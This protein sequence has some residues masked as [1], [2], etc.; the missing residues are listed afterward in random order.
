MMLLLP[1]HFVLFVVVPEAPEILRI[2][3][4]IDNME[5]YWQAAV[6]NPDGPV[7]DY[8]VRVKEKDESGN[9]KICTQHQTRSSSMMC[10]VNDLRSGK[11]YI[12]Q[13]AARNVA[14]YSAF[15]EAEA[16]TSKPAGIIFAFLMIEEH[17]HAN[18][19]FRIPA[20]LGSRINS[21]SVIFLVVRFTMFMVT[22][23]SCNDRIIN[24]KCIP[25]AMR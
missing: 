3:P 16:E 23:A 21:L 19:D 7:L 8:L 13:V 10:V 20:R 6:S 22:Y 25:T 14:G 1:L 2:D 15:T 17:S 24:L 11:V 4:G 5:I 9:W 12:V 18:F